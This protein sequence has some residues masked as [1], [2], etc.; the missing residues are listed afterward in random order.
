MLLAH[1]FWYHSIAGEYRTYADLRWY[2]PTR[3]VTGKE[4]P[5]KMTTTDSPANGSDLVEQLQR[6]YGLAEEAARD[7]ASDPEFAAMARSFIEARAASK[8]A[9]RRMDEAI[10]RL[11]EALRQRVARP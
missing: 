3:P 2:V 10:E 8:A 6:A 11:N 9:L 5:A 1:R 7:I 4:V